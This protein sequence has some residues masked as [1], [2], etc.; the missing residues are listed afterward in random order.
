M[1]LTVLFSSILLQ[2]VLIHD[3]QSDGVAS[4]LVGVTVTIEGIVTGVFEHLEGFFVQE[5]DIDA[6]TDDSTSEGIF[7]FL[8]AIPTVAVGDKVA[9]VGEVFE[10]NGLTELNDVTNVA[11]ASSG[12]TL[13]SN[14]VISDASS[15]NLET[16]EGML[17]S[18]A[19]KLVVTDTADF[20]RF[21]ELKL[22]LERLYQAT[23]LNPPG[24]LDPNPPGVVITLDDG[25]RQQY[26]DPISYAPSFGATDTIRSGFCINPNDLTGIAHYTFGAYK[27]EPTEDVTFD[28]S[29]NLRPSAPDDVG[30]T[31]KVAS[32]NVANYFTTIDSGDICGPNTAQECQGA[33]SEEELTR[34]KNKIVQAIVTLDADI[35]GL[36]EIENLAGSTA[37]RSLVDAIN[38]VAGAAIYN[39]VDTGIIGTSA[40]AV[41]LIF[42]PDKATAL[43]M[44]RVLDSSVDAR[45]DENNT[46]TL[47]QSFTETTTSEVITVAVNHFKVRGKVALNNKLA[48]SMK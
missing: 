29:T 4:P 47:A 20:G 7:V 37:V 23:Q 27:L 39:F 3:I 31:L 11:V 16:V 1:Q 26:P 21:G 5:E 44:F 12:N 32:F 10:F 36:V 41:G 13:P 2:V 42:K 9:V 6:D 40:V 35:V 8:N 15:F 17:V 28:A 14:V 48:T 45:F 33:D 30:G 46:P 25:S 19:E 22:S 24:A 38:V 34:Q 18:F 43:N